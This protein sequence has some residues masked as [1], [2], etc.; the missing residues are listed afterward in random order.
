MDNVLYNA[1]YNVQYNV[2]FNVLYNALYNAFVLS[3]L[4]ACWLFFVHVFVYIVYFCGVCAWGFVRGGLCAGVCARG[5]LCGLVRLIN[6]Y[7]INNIKYNSCMDMLSISYIMV[8][9]I[10]VSVYYGCHFLLFVSYWVV[11]CCKVLSVLDMT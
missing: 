2:L 8:C 6:R 11:K 10:V 4:V 1:L 7:L 5:W 3:L 9:I